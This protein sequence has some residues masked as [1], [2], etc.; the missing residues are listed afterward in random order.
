M[1]RVSTIEAGAGPERRTKGSDEG[2]G[3]RKRL[4]LLDG[5]SLSYRAFFALP[6]T[7]AT[8]TGQVTN[9][10]YGF[11]SM[12]IKLLSEERPDFIAV[13]FDLGTPKARLER[14]AEYKA[15]RRE[16]PDEFRQQLG[17]ILEV[18]ET[19][20]IPL[21]HHEEQEAHDLIAT[22]AV[23]ACRR[24][25]EVVIVTADRDFF[26][27]V[28]PGISVMFNRKGISDIVRYDVEAVTQRFGLPPE[29][30]LEYVALKGDPSD[31]IP[32]IP[33]V[34]EKTASQLIQQYG[35]V[36]ELLEHT[37]ELKP[38]VRAGVEEAG[39]QLARNKELAR[40]EC[41]L[42]LPVTVEDCVIGEWDRD[43]V[44]RLF[45]SL[46]F[47]TLLERLEELEMAGVAPAMEAVE[48]ALEEVSVAAVR[49]ELSG[50]HPKAVRVQA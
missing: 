4:F 29:K 30:Y 26:Q 35:S 49:K 20:Q 18:V 19:L 9:A 25:I 16:T 14:Y 33:G 21:I 10:V 38:R 46:E 32:G 41:D 37:A 48:L 43:E 24:G 45:T 36:E 5:H 31:N 34:G 22:L 6:E 2:D 1:P 7:L 44:R 13:A 47:R 8:T 17:L 27:L 28:Q 12:L 42:E 3:A 50:T 39:E 15:G 11:T 23:R 40:L